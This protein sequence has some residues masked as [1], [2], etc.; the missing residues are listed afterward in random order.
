MDDGTFI[1]P[2]IEKRLID[3]KKLKRMKKQL[4]QLNKKI[5]HSRKKRDGMVHKRNTFIYLGK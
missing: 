1:E 4:D 5:R 2:P 3:P